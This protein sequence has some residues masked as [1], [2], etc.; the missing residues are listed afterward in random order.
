MRTD[1]V[2]SGDSIKPATLDYHAAEPGVWSRKIDLLRWLPWAELGVLAAAW[3]SY[4]V[5]QFRNLPD[6]D[7]ALGFLPAVMIVVTFITLLYWMLTRE[8]RSPWVYWEGFLAHAVLIIAA[9]ADLGWFFHV[10]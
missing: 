2:N 8:S 10:L 4:R 6:N 9:V 5:I 3:T 1:G 7:F